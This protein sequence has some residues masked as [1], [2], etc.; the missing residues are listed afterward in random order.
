MSE[1]VNILQVSH[2]SVF[3]D[4]DS[5]VFRVEV[6][7]CDHR[8]C[9]RCRRYICSNAEDLCSRCLSVINLIDCEK[10]SAKSC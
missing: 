9:E 6:D 10:Q 7:K 4:S 3:E 2:V 8:P 1:L 5:P